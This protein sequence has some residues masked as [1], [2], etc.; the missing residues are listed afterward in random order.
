VSSVQVLPDG[1]RLR[2]LT[3]LLAQGAIAI[4][5][6]GRYRLDQAATALEQARRGARGAAIVL[7]PGDPRLSRP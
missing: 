5:V 6:A 3:G 2:R 7:Q 1:A 4:S